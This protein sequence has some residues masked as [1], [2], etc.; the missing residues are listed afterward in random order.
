VPNLK[1]ELW[2]CLYDIHYPQ[3]DSK[4][5][6]AILSFIRKNEVH[7]LLL[8]GDAL[9]LSCVSHWNKN[10]PGTKHKGELR[11]DL[12]GFDNNILQP[13]EALVPRGCD[14]VFLT[15]NHE[16]FLEQDLTD[17]MPELDGMLDFQAAPASRGSWLQGHSPRR[18]LSDR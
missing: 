10:L 3:F 7:G 6:R 1:P 14:K 12:D 9:D 15:G 16:R 8:G 18:R 17:E 2:V 5:F 11:R 4:T 13:I